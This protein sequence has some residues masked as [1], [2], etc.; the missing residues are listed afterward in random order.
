MMANRSES[1]IDFKAFRS[2]APFVLAGVFAG[3]SFFIYAPKQL[4][5]FSVGA[6][7]A[8]IAIYQ[9][10]LAGENRL[11]SEKTANI[12]ILGKPLNRFYQF[13]SGAFSASTGTGVAEMS[14]PMLEER[15][16][17]LTLKANATAILLEATADWAITAANLKVGNIRFDILVYTVT[18]VLI[19]GIIGPRIAPYLN[20]RI[21]K[22]VF[23][24]AVTS[25]GFIYMVTSWPSVISL[26]GA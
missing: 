14:Q 16:G 23:G 1:S 2:I 10:W 7:I 9:I 24:L 17:L 15:A 26:F 22:L 21:T 6:I 8:L 19:G 5:R 13:L 4:L 18:G 12:M 3:Y 20:P 25:L 11:G